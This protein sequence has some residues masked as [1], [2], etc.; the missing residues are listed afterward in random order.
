[1]G[2]ALEVS[3]IQALIDQPLSLRVVGLNAG[4]SIIMRARMCQWCSE[5]V[6]AADTSGIVDLGKQRPLSGTYDVADPMGLIWSMSLE[7]GSSEAN[8][9]EELLLSV[10]LRGSVQLFETGRRHYSDPRVVRILIREDGIA[11]VLW[12][13]G[14]TG[15][16]PAVIVLG[17]SLG[18]VRWSEAVAA[19]LASHGYAAFAVAYFAYDGLPPALANIP[20]EYFKTAIDWLR[21][22]ENVHA[23]RLTAVGMSRGGELAL[24][25][26]ATFPDITSVIAVAP[27]GLRHG[28][29]GVGGAAW[30]YRGAALPFVRVSQLH[31]AAAV[32]AASIPVEQIGGPI[33]F[34][35]GREDRI[36]PAT[37]LAEF[38]VARLEQHFHPYPFKHLSYADAGHAFFT[39]YLPIDLGR[40]SHPVTGRIYPTG[41]TTRG[42]AFVQADAWKQ[43][44]A[45]LEDHHRR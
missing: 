7:P 31:D 3:P 39:P 2:P 42:T 38:A 36:W 33:L 43:M 30:R 13:P 21:D 19:M 6:F 10:E 34:I 44:L 26:G 14:G 15:P 27:S 28:A 8:Y 24:Q 32:D 5:A 45:F 23:D 37:T 35:S 17:G 16:H 18:G 40:T 9:S 41:G 11:G 20:L 22:R 25:L 4:E 29:L 12:N 1:M